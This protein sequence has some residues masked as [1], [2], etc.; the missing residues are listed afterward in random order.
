MIAG[1]KDDLCTPEDIEELKS[2]IEGLDPDKPKNENVKLVYIENAGHNELI[3]G[4]DL[5]F[6]KDHVLPALIK[7]TKK[8]SVW[9]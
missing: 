7:Y 1:R 6:I 5:S 8:Y 9:P 4:P 2:I 3:T